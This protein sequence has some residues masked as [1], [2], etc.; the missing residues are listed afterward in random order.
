MSAVAPVLLLA[1]VAIGCSSGEVS[2]PPERRPVPSELEAGDP[3]VVNRPLPT[4]ARDGRDLPAI[5]APPSSTTTTTT[6]T[7]PAPKILPSDVLFDY[8]SATLKP[9]AT[10]VLVE[11]A[12]QILSS[13]PGARVIVTGHTD[14]RGGEAYNQVLS[15]DRAGAVAAA[16]VAAGLPSSNVNFTGAGESAPVA[17]DAPGGTFDEGLGAQNRRVE[18]QLIG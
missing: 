14:S 7:P 1:I 18:L 13:A 17:E 6:T 16:L 4:V 9:E 3:A 8:D 12:A 2:S 15:V 10:P 11:L 5:T